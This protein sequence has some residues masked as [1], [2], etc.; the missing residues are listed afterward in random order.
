MT[1]VMISTTVEKEIYE[2]IKANKWR[3]NELIESA[4]HYKD[5]DVKDALEMKERLEKMANQLDKTNKRLWELEGRFIEEVKKGDK[6]VLG[7]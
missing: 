3:V 5:L 7:K 6:N 4:I 1:K 2:R